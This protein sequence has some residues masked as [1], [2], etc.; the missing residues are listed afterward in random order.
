M[1]GWSISLVDN[2]DIKDVDVLFGFD[3]KNR[4]HENEYEESDILLLIS[5]D[6]TSTNKVKL[7][8]ILQDKK[9]YNDT[10]ANRLSPTHHNWEILDLINDATHFTPTSKLPLCPQSALHVSQENLRK[11]S[12][13]SKEIIS[14]RRSAQMMDVNRS[15]I[16]LEQF[17]IILQS[18]SHKE[19]DIHLALFVHDVEGLQSGLYL[20]LRDLQDLQN[21]KENFDESFIWSE[22]FAHLYLLKTGD[23]RAIAKSIS[24]SQDIAS[25]GA[26]SLGMIAKFA[27]VLNE[28]NP[29][30]YK[31]LYYECGAIGQ[32]LYLEATSLGLSATGI[33]CFLDDIMHKLLGLS[34]NNYQSFYHFTVGRA[35]IDA[36]VQ[37][38]K[39]YL[40]R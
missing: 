20:Y 30:K 29:Q 35:I 8:T 10:I 28:S 16:T 39:P 18:V 37:T 33:G 21:L 23:Y 32:Q 31:E 12:G 22:V 40:F 26:F 1:L 7:K 4:F 15:K 17:Q 25:D 27:S 24:C 6:Q 2:C 19:A 14:K 3:K 5:K 34:D 36:R 9:T 13:E 38:Q 11:P